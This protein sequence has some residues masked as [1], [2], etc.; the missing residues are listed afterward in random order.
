[1]NRKSRS[2]ILDAIE[3]KDGK[4]CAVGC[5]DK[6]G[7]GV[8]NKAADYWDRSS[9]FVVFVLQAKEPVF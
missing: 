3:R 6:L 8:G 9:L 4:L 5:G 1:M 7:F 2:G